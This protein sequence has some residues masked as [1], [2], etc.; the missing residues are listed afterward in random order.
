MKKIFYRCRA[1]GLSLFLVFQTFPLN[2]LAQ[3]DYSKD[4][5][6]ETLGLPA[7]QED[8]IPVTTKQG[9]TL[10][11]DGD[12][13]QNRSTQLASYTL[14]LNLDGGQVNTLQNSGWNQDS[15]QAYYWNRSLTE[16]E[17]GQGIS[18]TLDPTLGG[19]LPSQPYRAGYRFVGWNMEQSDY[20]ADTGQLVS[21]TKD[22]LIVARWEISTY[23]AVFQGATGEL[24]SVQVP[25]GATLWTHPD[26]PW[27]E[28]HVN[29][30]D[31]SAT[32]PI[33]LNDKTYDAVTVSRHRAGEAQEYY[34]TFTIEGSLYFTYGGNTPTKDGQHF[35]SWKQISG[36]TGFTV[37]DHAVFA[38][39][40]QA[41]KAYVFN[42]YF[43]YEDGTKAK[44]TLAITK[45][46]SEV[47][48][49]RLTFEV[50]FPTISHYQPSANPRDGITWENNHVTVDV[51]EVFGVGNTSNTNFLALTVIYKPAQISYKVQYYQQ[52]MGGTDTYNCVGETDPHDIAYGSKIIVMDRP[53][54]GQNVSFEGF[55]IRTDSQPAISEG[56]VLREETS[57]IEFDTSGVAIIKV[58]YDRASYFI[59][60]QTGTTEVQIDPIKVRYEDAI[61]SLDQYSKELSRTGYHKVTADDISWYGLDE[62]GKLVNVNNVNQIMP[63]YDLY[64]VVTWKPA[65]TSIRLAYWVESRNAASFQNTYTTTVN[66]ITT[67]AE[68]TVSLNGNVTIQGSGWPAATDQNEIVS[69]GFRQYLTN[70][71]GSEAYSTFFSYSPENTKACP[72]NVTNA[73]ETD[74]GEVKEGAITGDS[75]KVKVK[76]DGTTTINIY[77]TRNLYTLEFVLARQNGDQL[78]VANYTPGTFEQSGWQNVNFNSFVFHDFTDER[79]NTENSV[80]E[81][82]Y[83]NLNVEKTYRLKDAMVRDPRSPVG[84]Y[85]TKIIKN[86]TC[87]VYTLTA[88]FEADITSLWPTAQN[89]SETYNSHKYI[90]MGTDKLSYYRNVVTKNT[91]QH[92]ILNA[93]S[94]MDLNVVSA[95]TVEGNW[96]AKAD[97]GNGTAAHQM[98]AYWAKDPSEYHYY[99]LYEVLDTTLL[100]SD[101]GV[102]AFSAREAD[103][104]NYVAGQYVSWQGK[105]YTYSTTYDIQYSTSDRSGQ[106][107]PSRHGFTS[108]GKTFITGTDSTKG[109]NIYF[110]YSRETFTLDI[111]NIDGRYSIPPSLLT[112]PFDCLSHYGA[113]IQILQQL[114]WEAVNSDGTVS[115]RYGGALE[116]LG[117]EEVIAWLTDENRGKLK[118]PYQSAGENQYYFWRWYH[119]QIHTTPVDWV[120]DNEMHTMLSNNTLYAGWFTPRYTTSYVLN[121][122]TWVDTID[123]TLT[124]AETSNGHTAYFY[125]PHQAG[126]GDA[127]LYWYVQSK[128][129]DRLFVNTL[130]VCK[131]SDVAQKDETNSHWVLNDNLSLEEMLEH[132]SEDL[133]GS[134][135]VDHYYCYMGAGLEYNHEKVVNINSTVNFVLNEPLTPIRTG[136]TFKGWFYFDDEPVNGNK[137]YLKDVLSGT[138]SLAS[139]D[140][141]Y[142]YINHVGDAFF[143]HKDENGEL[144]Y[145]PEQTGYRFSYTNSASVVVRDLALYAAWEPKGDAKA[146][147]Y[148][149]VEEDTLNGATGFTPKD[150]SLISVNK[151]DT[152][153]IGS[154]K[155]CILEKEELANLY[156]G[157]TY[158]QT[159]WE[160]CTEQPNGKKW[161]PAQATIDVNADGR[162]QTVAEGDLASVTGNTFRITQTD[163]TYIYYAFFVYEPTDEVVYNIYSIDLSVAVAEGVLDSY[164]DTFD[165]SFQV[166]SV[167]PYLLGKEQK[168]VT[169]DSIDTTL[170]VENAPAVSGYTVYQDWSQVL[171][172]QTQSNANNIFF[173]YVRDNAQI[174]YSITYYMMVDG[175]YS[176]NNTVTFSQIPGVIGEIIPLTNLAGTFDRLVTMADTYS[177]YSQST[178]DAQKSLY[179]RYKNMTVTLNQGGDL[180]TFTVDTEVPDE[181]DLTALADVDQ[182][183]YVDS[184]SPTGDNLVVSDGTEVEVYL[185]TAQLI[186]QKVDTSQLPLAGAEFKLE[187]LVEDSSGSISYEDKTY[188]VDDSFQTASSLSGEDGKAIFYNLSARV[189]EDGNGYLYRLT[190]TKAPAGYNRLADP[191]YVITPYTVSETE[192][193]HYTVTYTVVNT[194]IPYLP[195]AGVFGGIY[196]TIFLGVGLMSCAM[197][198]GFYLWKKGRYS[199]KH[200]KKKIFPLH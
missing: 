22:T 167:A 36:G 65:T 149:L 137:I 91:N 150:K 23:T 184:W 174:Q 200:R 97:S 162:T 59:Y 69:Q 114:G 127:P 37:T 139:Y 66:N 126:S 101:E 123:Y 148:H 197:G 64:A 39:Q 152:I 112:T 193:T 4:A 182:D 100:T 122:G 49:G 175:G 186:V 77:Y 129:N 136:Y 81:T 14:T 80:E 26:T 111:Q 18:L 198:S 71:Y 54:F 84:R 86:Y 138:Q 156:T 87:Y 50:T 35:T 115:I 117:E 47:E 196:T 67:E 144:F 154:K 45:S 74:T 176:P 46:E 92:N 70:H 9:D 165:R 119:N 60:F 131:I 141:D 28:D 55:Q 158:T 116:P 2:A 135:L 130:Y 145:Y 104:H 147:I 103:G 183:Y 95:G 179:N 30:T 153:T 143:L 33:T 172:L 151:E 128:D 34:Y 42:V 85:G 76:G 191:L 195:A 12:S 6:E 142:V 168:S 164:L 163:G 27:T 68:L 133:Q 44:D 102:K 171:Q 83:G 56:I 94:T 134:R 190:E 51:E 24:W 180:S 48:D 15:F 72:G 89:I 113:E 57:N 194:G 29:W 32:M 58:F 5:S 192:E 99:F 161:L 177:T 90:S 188:R 61:P 78:Q 17:Q 79:V 169:V 181:L 199:G 170:V 82:S 31:D 25:Y 157:T 159:A 73:Q 40:F 118:Y 185:A 10:E 88:R 53:D 20:D 19:L 7:V 155:Y 187:R 106:N 1:L 140:E 63:P 132:S 21:I 120:N 93:Y 178:N 75:Y 13:T 125:Y 3:G 38:A 166:D 173:Y 11:V 189:F 62:S 110:F 96:S 41:E 105:V 160:Y 16:T 121:G 8:S 108:A 146:V 124:T 98:V 107:Q 52:Q 43:Y 109:G